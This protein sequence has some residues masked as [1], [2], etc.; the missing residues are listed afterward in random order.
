MSVNTVTAGV[1]AAHPDAAAAGLDALARGGNAVDAAVA[2]AFALAVVDPANC[3]IG[4]HGGCMVVAPA[5]DS[6][7]MQVDFNTR[8]PRGF[9]PQAF[10][11]APKTWRFAHGATTVTVPAVCAGLLAAQRRFGRL[12][13]ETVLAPAIALAQTGFAVGKDLAASFEWAARHHG[14]LTAEFKHIFFRDGEPLREGDPLRQPDLA[15]TLRIVSQQGEAAFRDGDLARAIASSVRAGGGFLSESDIADY[16]PR[17][18]PAQ[19]CGYGDATVFG[20]ALKESGFEILSRALT[21]LNGEDLG[22]N[23]SRAYI[24]RM[25]SALRMGW[26]QRRDRTQSVDSAVQ[27]TSHLCAVDPEGSVVSLT[28]THGPLWFGAGAIAAGTG[29][30]LN[31]A[32]NLL[33]KVQVDGSSDV[34][35][36]HNLTPVV[37]RV[38]NGASHAFG[39]PGGSRIPAVVL[40]A[41]IDVI[42]YRLRLAESIGLPRVSVDPGGR[43]EVEEE[44]RSIVPEAYV[45]ERHEYYGPA[46]GL[47]LSSDGRI[48]A[49]LD[50]RFNPAFARLGSRPPGTAKSD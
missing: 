35:A 21:E 10:A 9:D 45:I 47:T 50:P 18:G 27:H 43:I 24:D 38:A 16:E 33:R 17:I 2:T 20:A 8:C 31:A 44:L 22:P 26:A 11:R 32:A 28:F 40:Q 19:D 30:V 46:S 37:I 25:A 7:A 5:G 36:L 4:G 3:G 34:V 12:D 49:A 42:H 15:R 41:V 1:T 48:L 13:C 6:R 29:I 39:S 14:G 23:R